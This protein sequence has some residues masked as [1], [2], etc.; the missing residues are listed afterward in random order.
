M[1]TCL[2]IKRP[3]CD[4]AVAGFRQLPEIQYIDLDLYTFRALPAYQ[5]IL[6]ITALSESYDT[7]PPVDPKSS[8][9]AA[10]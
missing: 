8:R 10:R 9:F 5:N 6:F 2:S 4:R 1:R 3:F 7:V